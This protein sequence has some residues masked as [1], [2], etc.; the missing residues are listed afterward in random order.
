MGGGYGCG[1]G[2]RVGGGCTCLN[3]L[4]LLS[5]AAVCSF[6]FVCC[7]PSLLSVRPWLVLLSTAAV[8]TLP[9]MRG[10]VNVWCGA[11]YHLLCAKPPPIQ[12]LSLP[13]SSCIVDPYSLFLW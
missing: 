13:P 11:V 12:V 3:H 8:C 9:S 6:Q 1:A 2:G 5:I 10:V 4:V 7:C